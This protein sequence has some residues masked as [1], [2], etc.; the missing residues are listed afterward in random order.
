EVPLTASDQT[1]APANNS[2]LARADPTD[3]RFV[4]L[5]HRLDAPDFGCALELSGDGG[6]SWT[7]ASPVHALPDGVEK[8][9]APDVAFDRTGL[10]YYLFVGLAGVGNHPVGAFL[11]TSGDRGRTFGP[12]RQLL[13]P[14]NF[15]VRMAL[16]QSRGPRG[17]LHLVW[18][19]TGVE[20]PLGGFAAPP[21]PILSAYSDDGGT[22]FSP[23]VEVSDR[24]RP[25]AVA[26]TLSLGADHS[27]HVAYY[28]LGTDAV[29]YQGVEGPVW[30]GTWSVVLATSTDGGGHFGPG[31][32][33]D[34]RVVPFERVMLVL[35]MP[36]PALASEGRRVCLAWADGRAGDADVLARCSRDG[37]RRWAPA[38]RVN[39][40]AVGNGARQYLPGVGLGPGGRVDVIFY[41]R[42]D[43]PGR[44]ATEVYYTYSPD[45]G[46]HFAP[47]L[48]VTSEDMNPQVGQQY[49]GPAA[50]GLVEFGSR[51]AVL[52]RGDGALLAWTDTRNSKPYTTEQDIFSTQVIHPLPHQ[53]GWARFLGA[54]LA[55]CGAVG[56]V[57]GLRH[58]R[59]L[60]GRPAAVALTL[61]LGVGLPGCRAGT[62]DRGPLPVGA[63][64][65]HVTMDEYGFEPDRVI[66]A[67]RVVFRVHNAGRRTHMLTLV[68]LPEDMPAIDVQLHGETRRSLDDFAGIYPRQPGGDGTFAVDLVAG[69]RF[70]M[71]C[72]SQDPDE[73]VH[74]ALK[75][76]TYEFRPGAPG[77]AGTV[78]PPRTVPG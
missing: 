39:D 71:I 54:L 12:P 73:D 53:P 29:D 6:R 51:L 57:A 64:E 56:L 70:A 28:D 35:T 58:R 3:A 4:A 44:L 69:Q 33:V 77:T 34:D 76:M 8:C 37:G 75:G 66:P 20:P 59:P 49:V 61:T 10:L 5:A 46:Q 2:P 45:G 43:D 40:D 60:A 72:F 22:T 78:P 32:V 23:P 30:D 1:V 50:E 17:R 67:G 13:G 65:V 7:P 21:N 38:R 19:H 48:R 74:H 27:V 31:V 62:A 14:A 63:P 24:S 11:A 16:D 15:G 42:R 26:P 55:G 52:S 25:R 68:P 36:P 18:V 47:N 9:Y 41:D